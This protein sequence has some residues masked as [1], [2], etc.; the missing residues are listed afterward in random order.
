MHRFSDAFLTSSGRIGR[1]A[2]IASG[3]PVLLIWAAYDLY[4]PVFLRGLIGGI[5]AVVL[6][7]VGANLLSQRLHDR[8]R[9]GWWSGPILLLI[10]MAL[11]LLLH[12]GQAPID[13]LAAVLLVPVSVDLI[14]LPG[15]KAFNRYGAP[16]TGGSAG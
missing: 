11:P 12:G 10:A 8:G 7:F 14:L 13:G 15:Q 9:S 1:L 4:A 3:V 6:L 5:I 2:F 16:L